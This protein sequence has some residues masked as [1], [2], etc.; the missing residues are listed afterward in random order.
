MYNTFAYENK[1]IGS[2]QYNLLKAGFVGCQ[3]LIKTGLW[4]VALEAC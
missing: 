4:P 3:G 2:I 1:L